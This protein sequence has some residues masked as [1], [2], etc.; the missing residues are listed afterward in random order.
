MRA[1]RNQAHEAQSVNKTVAAAVSAFGASAK[2]K[3]ANIAISGAPEDQLRGPLEDLV[4]DLSEIGACLPA[5]LI[6]SVKRV[7]PT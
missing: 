2:A 3:L 6:S 5:L 4:R 1:G 7:F